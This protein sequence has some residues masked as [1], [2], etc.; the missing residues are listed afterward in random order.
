MTFLYLDTETYSEVP[1]TNGTHAYAE[2]AE[3]MLITYAADDEPVEALDMTHD[4]TQYEDAYARFRELLE[5]PAV[6]LVMQNGAGFDRTVFRHA[7][8]I[9]LPI[10]R[11]FD[12]MVCALAHGLPG[13]LGILCAVFGITGDEAKDK[14]GRELINLFCKPRPKGHNLRRATRETHP[15]EWQD[16]IAYAKSDIAAMRAV[17]KRLPTWNYRDRE[18]DLWHLD[19]K[20]NDRGVCVDVD[21]ARAAIEAVDRAQR[22]LARRTSLSTNG[23]VGSAT[24]RD[25]LLKYILMDYGVDLPDLTMS[26]LERRIDDHDLPPQLRELLAIRLQAT[27]S[28]TSKYKK[29]VGAVS[30]DGRMRGTLQF[31]GA[32]RTGRWAGRTFQP[33]NLPRPVL[34]Q[35]E[36]D[37]GIQALKAGCAELIT[38]NVMQ[39]ASSCIRGCIVAPAGKKL[40]VSDLSNIE[41]RAAA[42]LVGE[43]WKLDAFR[44]FDAGAG[45]DL[46][47]IAYAK[48]FRIDPAAVT[49]DQRQVGK[50]M[51]LMLQYEGGVGAFITGAATYGIDL[52]GLADIAWDTIP[53]AIKRE[54]AGAWDWATKKDKTYG[55]SQ[56]AYIVCDSLKRMWRNAHTAISPY[57][58]ELEESAV[59][60]INQPGKTIPAG[61]LRLRR[62]GAW[63]RMVLP[64]GRALC[65]ASP[66]A[67]DGKVSYMGVNQYS[68]KWSRLKTYGGKLFENATQAVARDVMAANMPAIEEYYDIVLSVHD[69]LITEAPD[70]PDYNTDHLSSLLATPPAWALD[71]PLAA[72]GFEAYRYRKE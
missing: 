66:R 36:I 7:M 13:G 43:H 44:A 45:D 16:F 50:V 25:K 18:L 69:E 56:K 20:I 11:I 22:D 37:N 40:V 51:E 54:A 23:L 64:S 35:K 19:Q 52:D 62:D 5:D 55:L 30:A 68:R 53:D 17:H 71:M 3:I 4:D 60:A 61:K 12:T 28:S 14:R 46:Y 48:A 32:S 34:K 1:I 49:K 6:T 26:T 8:G 31:C 65:Y 58:K 72:G 47:K 15:A 27:T 10:E 24:Q 2:G 41:G 63:L 67:E 57:W 70:A 39:L 42:W 9:E 38:D 59:A 33:Q 21:L 29:L